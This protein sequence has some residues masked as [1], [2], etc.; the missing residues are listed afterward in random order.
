MLLKFLNMTDMKVLASMVYKFLDKKS[1][2]ISDKS[3]SGGAMEFEIMS[4]K[5]LAEELNK[6]I[7]R[8]P[9]KWNVSLAFIDNGMLI[10]PIWNY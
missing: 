2:S 10:W 8:N 9:K 5:E 6:P 1:A 3:A 4:N 7:I